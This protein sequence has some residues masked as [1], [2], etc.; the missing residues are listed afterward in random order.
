MPSVPESNT[1]STPTVSEMRRPYRM[2]EKTSRPCSSVPSRNGLWPSAVH[3][4]EM[5][6]FIS[7]KLRGIERV[8]HREQRRKDRQ[9]EK[10][11]G[12]GRRDHG[13]LR[14]AERIEDVAFDDAAEQMA[15]AGP[16]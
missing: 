11:H 15:V 10:Q 9:Q 13:E 12:D 1:P 16:V 7:C 2:A 3:S 4:G 8:L 6:E 5:R 14:A